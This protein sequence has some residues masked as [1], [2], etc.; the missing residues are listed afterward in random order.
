MTFF[1]R[2]RWRVSS[3]NKELDYFDIAGILQAKSYQ[4]NALGLIAMQN[5]VYSSE[6]QALRYVE[7]LINDLEG[8]KEILNRKIAKQK[9][10]IRDERF[11]EKY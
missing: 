1:I 6:Y 11:E 7:N 9:E 5:C 4:F 3:M 8:Y 10:E 2:L